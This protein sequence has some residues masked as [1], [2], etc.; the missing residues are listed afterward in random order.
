MNNEN[1]SMYINVKEEGF[2]SKLLDPLK[3]EISLKPITIKELIVLKV[4]DEF[5]KICSK[6]FTLSQKGQS[7]TQEKTKNRSKNM[8]LEQNVYRA[9]EGF[10]KNV[11]FI[12]IND[13]QAENLN[14]KII[15]QENTTITFIKLMPLVGG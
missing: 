13:N 2:I 14:D 6:D 5:E 3:I 10:Q 11:F 4:T 9:L 8:D 1:T 15:I 7:Q 12:L